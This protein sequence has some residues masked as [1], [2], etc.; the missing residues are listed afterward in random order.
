MKYEQFLKDINT[1]LISII[2]RRLTLQQQ[3]IAR[4]LYN[5]RYTVDEAVGTLLTKI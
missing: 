3:K 4:K 5:Q 2:G 1:T